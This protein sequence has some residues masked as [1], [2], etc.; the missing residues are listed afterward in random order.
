MRYYYN[1]FNRAFDV[2]EP[3]ELARGSRPECDCRSA[4]DIVRRA[5][6]LGEVE[7]NRL[8][9]E[10]VDVTEVDGAAATADVRYSTAP[11]RVIG[12][13]GAVQATLKAESGAH[14]GLVLTR[15]GTGWLVAKVTVL[16]G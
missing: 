13:D 16:G 15:D 4:V 12:P 5:L 14:R 6:S 1:G 8:S 7:G 11:G 2:R 3:D 10:S 9:I